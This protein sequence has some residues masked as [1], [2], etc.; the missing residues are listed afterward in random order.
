MESFAI[1]G[2]YKRS[3][4]LFVCRHGYKVGLYKCGFKL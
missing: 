2:V 1:L 4:L 3:D